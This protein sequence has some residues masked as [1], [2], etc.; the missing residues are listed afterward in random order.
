MSDLGR[1]V[2]LPVPLDPDQ[3]PLEVLPPATLG[4]FARIDVF[5][6]ENAKAARRFLKPLVGDRPLQSLELVEWNANQRRLSAE[7]ALEPL[8]HGRDIGLLSDAGCPAVADPGADL[9][10]AAHRLGARV[11]PAI[12]PSALL[13]ALMASGMG[14]QRFGFA[15]YLPSEADARRQALRA[16][17]LR[18]AAGDETI[19]FIETP[20]RNEAMV[21]AA[22]DVLAPDTVFMSASG[23]SLPSERIVSRPIAEWRRTGSGAAGAVDRRIPAVFGL[24]AVALRR[25]GS[26][27]PRRGTG[28][29]SRLERR[30]KAGRKLRPHLSRKP[31]GD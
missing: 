12:G 30:T 11:V 8:R 5:V 15:G 18:S 14:G 21:E 20:Y 4:H 26:A 17:E 29:E 25:A 31:L 13:L 7:E 6:V 24:K 19:L 9:V 3:S 1:L 16:L 2:L 10:A 27:D 28:I 22:I 23:L